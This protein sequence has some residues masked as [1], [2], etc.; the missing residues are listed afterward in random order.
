MKYI[1][2]GLRV[3]PL[4]FLSICIAALNL[5][6]L[7]LQSIVLR[8]ISF[9]YYVITCDILSFRHRFITVSL[10]FDFV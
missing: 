10:L 4:I 3:R 7:F 6:P 8:D 5:F 1:Y 2:C 9:A